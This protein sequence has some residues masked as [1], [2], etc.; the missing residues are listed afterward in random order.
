[1]WT[2]SQ[3]EVPVPEG[4]KPFFRIDCNDPDA[5]KR[6][7]PNLRIITRNL[8]R[9]DKPESRYRI[10]NLNPDETG[11]D[12]L[13]ASGSGQF[14]AVNFL[15]LA[16]GLRK[17]AA[18][19]EVYVIDLRRESH[20]LLNGISISW[21]MSHNW[22]NRGASAE[23]I[24]RDQ[25]ERFGPLV[26]RTVTAYPRKGNM[27]AESGVIDQVET[28]QTEQELVER[29][30]FHYVRIPVLDHSW[31]APEEVDMFLTLLKGLDPD[32]VWLHFHCAA[33]KGRTTSFLYMLDRIRNPEVDMTDQMIRQAMLG[34]TYLLFTDGEDAFK[35]TIYNERSC[36]SRLFSTY[37][38]ENRR[39][40]CA[41]TW[42]D[43]LRQRLCK[44]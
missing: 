24:L 38:E 33:G 2:C 42:S 44:A 12:T 31:P 5:W 27:R 3:M 4:F 37:V 35:Q 32:R 28:F 18:G 43:W 19:K 8:Y 7:V 41:L 9:L 14:S 22:S 29:E 1:M 23:E 16:D 21:Y 10:S 6:D 15:R 17:A 13:H 26:G 39:E 36:M 40:A 25:E 11:L 30:G 34:G 20:A